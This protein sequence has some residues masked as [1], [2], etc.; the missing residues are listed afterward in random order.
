MVAVFAVVGA[1]GHGAGTEL[2][3]DDVLHVV[4]GVA[5][6]SGVDLDAHHSEGVDRSSADAAA[7]EL[8]DA[9]VLQVDGEC[10]VTVAAVVYD[11]GGHDLTILDLVDLELLGVAEVLENLSVLVG[12]SYE[13]NTGMSVNAY[14]CC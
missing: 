10:L 6:E 11:L 4:V 8:G 12:G 3:V 7:D 1:V 13:H 9:H 2:S 14:K 5:G